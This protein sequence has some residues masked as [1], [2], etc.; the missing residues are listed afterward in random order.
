MIWRCGEEGS[1]MPPTELYNEGWLLRLLLDWFSR[2]PNTEHT[3]SVP[4]EGR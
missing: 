3:L 2:H 1:V 4:T